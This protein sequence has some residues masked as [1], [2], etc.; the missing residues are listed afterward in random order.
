MSLKEP[1]EDTSCLGKMISSKEKTLENSSIIYL[2]ILC[3]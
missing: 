3:D 2:L 1:T